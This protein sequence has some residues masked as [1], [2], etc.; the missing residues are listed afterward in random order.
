MRISVGTTVHGEFVLNEDMLTEHCFICGPTGLG[1]SKLMELMAMQIILHGR[2][3]TFIDKDSRTVDDLFMRIVEYR[4]RFTPFEQREI[5]Y[6]KPSPDMLWSYDPAQTHLT[7]KE[8]D[9]WLAR[10]VETVAKA[11]GRKQGLPDFKDQPRRERVLTDVLFM[12]L[13]RGKDGKSLGLHRALDALD[14]MGTGDWWNLFNHVGEQL[15]RPIA[16]DL[17]HLQGLPRR[18]RERETESTRNILRAFLSPVVREMLAHKAATIDL[19]EAVRRGATVLVSLG[20]TPFFSAEQGDAI[21]AMVINDIVDACWF[22]ENRH[23]LFVEEAASILGEDFGKILDRARKHRLSMFLSA[24][25]LAGLKDRHTDIEVRALTQPGIHISFQQKADLDTWA[26]LFGTGMLNFALNW[27]PVDRPDGYDWH[28][29]PERS[30]SH[31]TQKTWGSGGSMTTT[32]GQGGSSSTTDSVADGVNHSDSASLA[33]GHT[34]GRT[35]GTSLQDASNSGFSHRGDTPETFNGGVSRSHGT[36]ESE[37]EQDSRTATSGES[38]GYTRTVTQGRTSGG[39]WS[40][41]VA[42]G[43]TFH[44]GGAETEQQSLSLRHIPLAR[45]REEW[46]PNGLIIPLDVQ[47]AAI[48]KVLRTLGRGEIMVAV[49][50]LPTA[51]A[52]VHDVPDP[53]EGRLLWG[54]AETGYFLRWLWQVHDCFFIPT[55]S[56]KWVRRRATNG[57]SNGSS[58]RRRS[59]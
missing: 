23:Y 6:L 44:E 22:V 29:V 30:F 51:I 38:D 39:N 31:G 20:E 21:A 33:D 54:E 14:L 17:V 13:T 1:K 43:Q 46:Y 28:L 3:L 5:Y 56:E 15:D 35:Q 11:L 4:D 8:Y 24:Q 26:E 48:K 49:K 58:T 40:H 45:H 59:Q 32:D 41:A 19:V 16:A 12:V 42:H 18:D 47:Y 50:N 10:R 27:R 34:L 2:G 25:S 52:T 37:N 53:F 7:G 9:Y 36:N 55:E 57:S